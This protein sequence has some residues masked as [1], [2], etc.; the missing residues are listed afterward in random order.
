LAAAITIAQTGRSVLVL[1]AA[2]KAGGGIR[3]K[4]LTIPGFRHDVCASVHP[5]AVASPFFRSLHLE[6]YGLEWLHPPTPLAHPLD[7]DP[8]VLL[9]RSID[10]TSRGLGVDGYS[11]GRLMEPFVKNWEQLVQ[12]VLSPLHFPAHPL[13]SLPFSLKG[14]L[15]ARTAADRWFDTKRAKALFAGN[16]CHS[17]LPLESISSAAFGLMLGM[18]GHAVGW[19]L[20]K[21]G[22][23]ALAEALSSCLRSLG[24]KIILDRPVSSLEE[25]P[26][27]QIMLFDVSP[28]QMESIVGD[29][30]P[31]NYR[32]RLKKHRHGPGVFKIDWA[33]QGA[34]P[35]KDP[36]CLKAGTL[37]LG[38]TLEEIAASERQVWSGIAPEKPFVLLSQA[39]LFD[40]TRAPEG[41]H[42]AWAYCH[43]PNGCAIDMTDAIENQVQR[44]APGFRDLILAKHIMSP[45][46]MEEY[47][48]NY[49][50][51]DIVGGIQDFRH[52]FIRP[53]GRWEAYATP[54]KG[55]YMC[56][57]SMPPGGGVHGM[58]GHLAAMKAL[59]E[60]RPTGR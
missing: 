26:G 31:A 57:A 7:N 30:F 23:Q 40:A 29:R 48:P 17:I 58:C 6:N 8:A 9:E 43:V 44:F 25:L 4:E 27:S 38:G 46:R 28:S 50:G 32:L 1:E 36:A 5:L 49:I 41:M 20:V 55:I 47:N 2:E 54:V 52:L 56:S 13:T 18:L 39:S 24:G 22:S 42:T 3:T 35:W 53:F 34:I 51:G 16:A 11:Y 19:P 15:S 12:D 14:I 21:G 59:K 33:L 10:D 37:H 60:M 45:A